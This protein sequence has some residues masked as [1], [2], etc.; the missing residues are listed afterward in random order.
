MAHRAVAALGFALGLLLAGTAAADE[1][2]VVFV[3]NDALTKDRLLA[4]V[5]V[6]AAASAGAAPAA[7]GTTD[8]QGRVTLTLAPGEWLISYAL[9]GYVPLADT[10]LTVVSAGQQVT[11]SLLP[12][13]ESEGG[14]SGAPIQHRIALV[15]NWGSEQDRQVRDADS[16]LAVDETHVYFG[17]KV[18]A[19]GASHLELDVDDMDWGGPET[20]TVRDPEPGHYVYWVHD[21]SGG[22]GALGGSEVVV[23]LLVDDAVA[24][25]WRAPPTATAR[26]WRPFAR[27]EVDEA[28]AVRVVAFEEPELQRGLDREVPAQVEQAVGWRAADNGAQGDLGAVCCGAIGL[29][30]A[31]GVAAGL[32]RRALQK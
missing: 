29:V 28:G 19:R 17:H 10:P 18:D 20:V 11:T 32:L 15:L 23:R 8:A 3:V 22:P 6:S 5:Q 31:I 2:P 13:L 4:G 1:L 16:H 24:G 7:R 14:A 26:V 12:S 27:L 30:V 21:W 9:A 25:E